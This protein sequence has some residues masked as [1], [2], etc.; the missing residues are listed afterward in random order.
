VTVLRKT[1]SLASPGQGP[2][3]LVQRRS[4]AASPDRVRVHQHRGRSQAEDRD[5]HK[6]N[7][8]CLAVVGGALRDY[9]LDRGEL[10]DDPLVAAVPVSTQLQAEG[11][12]A[13]RSPTC[14]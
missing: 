6:F 13:T 8:V 2:S 12:G 14:G 7:D 4:G 11:A 9:L 5:G 1:K 3:E 10:P